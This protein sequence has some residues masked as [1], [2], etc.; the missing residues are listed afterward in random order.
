M[1]KSNAEDRKV[2]E[3]QKKGDLLWQNFM[4]QIEPI[5]KK[6]AQKLDARLV[7]T[8]CELLKVLLIHRNREQGLILSELGGYLAGEDQ[9]PAGVKRIA[10]LLHSER[11]SAE[12]IEDHLWDQA[13]ERVNELQHPQNEVY[14]IWDESVLEKPES[15]KSERLCPVR[16]SKAARLKRIKPGYFNPPGGRPIFVPGFNWLQ[17]LV[18]GLQGVPT[19]AHLRWWTSRGEDASNKR[20]EES[21][22]LQKVHQ[23]WGA[24]VIHIWDRGFASHPWLH[25]VL[26]RSLRFIVRWRKDFKLVDT[27]G[28][29]LAAWKIT[30]GKRSWGFRM[31]YDAKR[32]C[33]RKTGIIATPVWLPDHSKPL[34]LV[35]SRPGAGRPPWYLLTTDP[36]E[37]EDDAWRV[38]LAYNRRWQVEMS[39]RFTK[40]ELAFESPRLQKWQPRLK[41]M[42]LSALV[43]SFLLSLLS[44]ANHFIRSWLFANWCHRTGVRNLKAALPLYRLRFAL[45]HLFLFL[46][47]FTPDL[48]NPG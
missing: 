9:A 48:L 20:R 13:N 8:L 12:W 43:F 35:V 25:Q 28:R 11:W 30:R 32:R 42:Y 18:V 1:Y 27:Q 29:A 15:I 45:S 36:I 6:I 41:L 17:V 47:Q 40:S 14:V 37:T 34:W 26:A 10:N 2:Q 38:V 22:V 5:V 44:P 31:I 16:S 46:K 3:C 23:L 21:I 24:M 33:Y 4:V 7:K 39:I 19:L